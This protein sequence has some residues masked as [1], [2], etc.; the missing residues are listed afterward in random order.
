MIDLQKNYID[1]KIA[2]AKEMGKPVNGNVLIELVL[3]ARKT[4]NDEQK[5]ELIQ[6]IETVYDKVGIALVERALADGT[7]TDNEWSIY[8]NWGIDAKEICNVLQAYYAEKDGMVS[9]DDNPIIVVE[10]F[11]A[12]Y[13]H[14]DTFQQR[15]GVRIMSVQE[16]LRYMNNG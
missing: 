12:V 2:K 1:E 13:L 9:K 5:V 4:F 16:A 14:K 11:Q 6:F 15:F 3:F 10:D 7:M 8:Q